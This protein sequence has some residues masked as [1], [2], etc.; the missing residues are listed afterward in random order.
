M[1]K[2]ILLTLLIF[3][4]FVCS[5]KKQEAVSD[6]DIPFPADSD[7]AYYQAQCDSGIQTFWA[8]IKAISSAFL[9]NSRFVD[10][11]AKFSDIRIVSEGPSNGAVEVNLGKTRLELG[12]IRK[13]QVAGKKAIWQVVSAKEIP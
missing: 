4:S 11:G 2:A 1:K 5:E 12:L 8:D 3:A 6:P 13:Y 9:N 10:R 7:M